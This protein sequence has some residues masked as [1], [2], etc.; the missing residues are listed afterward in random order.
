[1]LTLAIIVA[2]LGLWAFFGPVFFVGK[3]RHALSLRCPACRHL[4]RAAGMGRF[5]C[6]MCGH[7]FVEGPAGSLTLLAV[8]I[9]GGALLLF[10]IFISFAPMAREND[11]N[12]PA[13]TSAWLGIFLLNTFHTKRFPNIYSD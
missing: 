12:V 11:I 8:G 9:I 10:C 7:H 3:E 13:V 5:R 1:M 4:G 6:S 2:M